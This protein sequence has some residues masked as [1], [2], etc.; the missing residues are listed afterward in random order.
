[1]KQLRSAQSGGH[2]RRFSRDFLPLFSAGGCCEQFWHGQKCPL[3][4]CSSSISSADH[5][6]THLPK[7]TKDGSKEAVMAC[8]MP[9][10]C[11]FPSL[12]SC[13]K[14][15]LSTHK[16]PCFAL[17]RWSCAPSGRREKFPQA[18]GFERLIPYLRVRKPC[19]ASMAIK[20]DGD[21]KGLIQ[22]GL[23]CKAGDVASPDPL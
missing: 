19:P 20:K 17:G 11:E 23:V 14:R 13:P 18:L 6:V 5:S 22:L 8:D 10:L 7:S 15:S 12:D 4:C 9:E 1:M 16:G 21:D 2:D 3:L